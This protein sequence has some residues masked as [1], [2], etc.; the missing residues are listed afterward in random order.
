MKVNVEKILRAKRRPRGESLTVIS[1]G[2]LSMM[3]KLGA[4]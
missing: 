4:R 1:P 2:K 3:S